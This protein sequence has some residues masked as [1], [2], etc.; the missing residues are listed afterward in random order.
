M[1]VGQGSRLNGDPMDAE[2]KARGDLLECRIGAFA[3][4]QAIGND[5]DLMAAVGLTVGEVDDV[6]EN[7]A[8]WRTHR[9]QDFER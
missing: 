2:R 4:G 8:H 5:S 9:V 6:A 7:A 3:A 1:S